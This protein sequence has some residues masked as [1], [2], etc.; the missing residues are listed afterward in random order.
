MDSGGALRSTAMFVGSGAIAE[1][2][3]HLFERQVAPH[4]LSPA[5]AAPEFPYR[6]VER[7]AS[8]ILGVDATPHVCASL[9][10]LALLCEYPGPALIT[11]LEGYRT[12][13]NNGV[14]GPEGIPGLADEVGERFKARL[15]ALKETLEEFRKAF[16]D[17]SLVG[18]AVEELARLYGLALD[19]RAEDPLL[20]L[21]IYFPVFNPQKLAEH[22]AR[23]PAC[24]ILQRRAGDV[25]ALSRDGLH[26]FRPAPS[27]GEVEL[28]SCF[29]GLHSQTHF[30]TSHLDASGR[31]L[32][33]TQAQGPTAG[34]PFY[35]SCDKGRR[36][37]SSE[38]CRTEPWR[39]FSHAE[40]RLCW[41]APGV[42]LTLGPGVVE[43][44][45]Q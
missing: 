28:S 11:L 15:P 31:F 40:E 44:E 6:V 17:R 43:K 27:A 14:P 18:K 9:V 34:C 16:E 4:P 36:T 8:H 13:R 2:L 22:S 38:T 7:I 45:E 23:F 10:T 37:S 41:Y 32:P 26:S 29:R 25:E 24:D 1:S 33:S 39:T 5:H 12:A 3:A 35:T 30:A 19:A 21:P 42:R 20:D